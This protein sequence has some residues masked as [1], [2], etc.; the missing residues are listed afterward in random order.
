MK[1]NRETGKVEIGPENVIFPNF[2]LEKKGIHID[3]D[4]GVKYERG[5]D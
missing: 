4:S 2:I 3:A 1:K 5:S